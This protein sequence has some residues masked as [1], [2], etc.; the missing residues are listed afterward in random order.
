MASSTTERPR[1]RLPSRASTPNQI[2]S[3]LRLA[4]R[5]LGLIARTSP[6]LTALV[7]L[8]SLFPMVLPIAQVW[9][10]KV[11]VDDLSAASGDGDASTAIG[12]AILYGLTFVIPALTMPIS[13][14]IYATI[15]ER[16]IAAIDRALLQAGMRLP[17]LYRIESPAFHD[18]LRLLAQVSS[19][20]PV[21]LVAIQ[22][23]LGIIVT[24][25]GLLILI[26]TLNPVLPVLL[27][28]A[29]IPDLMVVRGQNQAVW[30]AMQDH[31]RAAREMDY[32]VRV[33]TEPAA[34][35]EV[36]VFGLGPFF[37]ARF[38]ERF[39]VARDEVKTIRLT[40]LYRTLACGAL[41]AVSLGAGL[42]YVADQAG[43]GNLTLGDIALYTN[44]VIQLQS[45]IYGIPAWFGGYLE[46][47]PYLRAFFR[48][49]DTAAP[50]ISLPPPGT[51]HPTPDPIATGVTVDSVSFTYPEQDAAI[52]QNITAHIPPGQITALVGANGAGKTTLVKLLTRLYDPVSGRITLDGHDLAAYDLTA[53]RQGMSVAFQDAA[54]FALTLRDNIA[55]GSAHQTASPDQDRI[56]TAARW[57][58][59]NTI[60][61]KLPRGFDTELTRRFDDGTDL[62]GGEWQKVALA[63][64]AMRDAPLLI[65]DEPNS[66]LDAEAEHQ[67]LENIRV[68]AAGRT[69]L[70]IS[71]RLSTVRMA[72]HI[73]V[74]EDGRI[75]ESG[76]HDDLIAGGGQYARLFAMQADRFA[77]GPEPA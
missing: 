46:T 3:G 77:D 63:R 45:M 66:A 18:D 73:L 44:A 76:S 19:R 36:R 20:L 62:S 17:D 67:L 7:G 49:Q 54:R 39:T 8:L 2:L 57:S 14:T 31:S 52:L 69:T 25:S 11:I 47:V 16:S 53:L 68:R 21:L 22:E 24:V 55:V 30:N 1:F 38:H 42:W 51:G 28:L 29:A 56:A 74:I 9:L 64:G 48:L 58:G 33:V 34:A 40:F 37:L 6:R 43:D 35:K 5:G 59:A 61:A 65:L 72:D 26:A 15:E 75:R 60:A 10:A 23:W 12:P 27:A 32:A 71:H 41:Y 50:V 70:V 13:Q 4:G